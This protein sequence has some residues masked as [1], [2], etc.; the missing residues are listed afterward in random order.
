MIKTET[1]KKDHGTL[2]YLDYVYRD[3]YE[4]KEG[5]EVI[6]K[7]LGLKILTKFVELDKNL[8]ELD[9]EKE[10]LEEV[11]KIV[12]PYDRLNFKNEKNYDK[13][14]HSR[15]NLSKLISAG[16]VVAMDGRRGPAKNVLINRED[17]QELLLEEERDALQRMYEVWFTEKPLEYVL[18]WR[19]GALDEPGIVLIKNEEKYTFVSVGFHPEA[20]FCK[21]N[22]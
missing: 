20:Q 21:I 14:K 3:D 12:K 8:S 6:P 15:L 5:G 19:N 2:S 18:V 17:F 1:I 4:K 7:E 11:D 9:E 22:V 10:F 16:S 13:K